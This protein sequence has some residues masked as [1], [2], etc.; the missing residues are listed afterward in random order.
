MGS[1]V[2][3][4]CSWCGG[5]G[6]V[7]AGPTSPAKARCGVCAGLG[8]S[9]MGSDTIACPL[10]QGSGEANEAGGLL[11]VILGHDRPCPRCKGTGWVM[12]G[13]AG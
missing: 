6:Q 12:P 5:S 10:C 13:A 7:D 11:D 4:T 1:P 2:N 8:Y 3:R 9:V